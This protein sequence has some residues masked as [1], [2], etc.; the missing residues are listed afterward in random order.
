[1]TYLIPTTEPFFFPAGSTGCLLIHG[2][3]G[4]PKEMRWMG[5]HL[6]REGFS[7]LGIR[8]AGHATRPEDML[9]ARWRDWLACVEDGYHLLAGV[10]ERIYVAGLS[11]GGCLALLFAADHPVAGVIAMSTPFALPKDPRLP[12]I[13]VLR[14][15]TPRV[16]KGASDWRDEQAERDHVAYPDYPTRA[17]MELRDLLAEMRAAL[18]RLSAPALLIHSC[19]DEAV[20]FASMQAIFERLGSAD[21]C[22]LPIEDS[23]HV[24]TRDQTRQQVFQAAVQFIRRTTP[25]SS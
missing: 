7:A 25:A 6:A 11:M 16:A 5:E 21:R 14:W 9:R 2:F 13:G 10:A 15:I 18:P 4:T 8:L 12:F 22:M 17:V 3:T 24:I 23:G 20:P 1:M 19:Q